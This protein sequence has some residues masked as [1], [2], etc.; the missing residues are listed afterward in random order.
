MKGDV[1]L[2]VVSHRLSPYSEWTLPCLVD[3]VFYICILLGAQHGLFLELNIEQYEYTVGEK[4]LAGVKVDWQI[5][6]KYELMLFNA[7]PSTTRP[8]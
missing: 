8:H 7:T 1:T 2:Y 3:R 6:F 5:S 4:S